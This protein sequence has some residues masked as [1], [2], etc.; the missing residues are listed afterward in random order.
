[1]DSTFATF[2][3]FTMLLLCLQLRTLVVLS[4]SSLGWSCLYPL[5]VAFVVALRDPLP[6]CA[7]VIVADCGVSWLWFISTAELDR[8]QSLIATL[9]SPALCMK[10][11]H[12]VYSIIS[13]FRRSRDNWILLRTYV[14]IL[15]QNV[16]ITSI[17][18]RFQTHI[19]C[20]QQV[21]MIGCQP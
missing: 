3:A 7:F 20:N 8:Y 21:R 17:W 11:I 12:T 14:S 15:R 10:Y 1:M 9:T 4:L 2:P 5:L 13:A 19:S 18:S 16:P 6:H